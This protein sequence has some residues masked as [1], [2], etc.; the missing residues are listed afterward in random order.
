MCKLSVI[1]PGI[2]GHLASHCSA[3][4]EVCSSL[5]PYGR[6]WAGQLLSPL[7]P[8]DLSSCGTSP[9]ESAWFAQTAA[10]QDN[11]HTLT[12]PVSCSE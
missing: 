5:L 1:W 2:A 3:V 11:S 8:L 6:P 9:A 12:H 4:A 7:S 10:N